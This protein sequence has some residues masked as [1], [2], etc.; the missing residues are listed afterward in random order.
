MS[1]VTLC[2]EI[3]L[4]T[5]KEMAVPAS[6]VIYSIKHLLQVKC[7]LIK[8]LENNC[9]LKCKRMDIAEP[10]LSHTMLLIMKS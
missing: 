8:V 6:L 4:F 3:N 9:A 10:Y 2:G 5:S 1:H 7:G